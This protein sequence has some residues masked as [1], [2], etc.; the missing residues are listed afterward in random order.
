MKLVQVFTIRMTGRT[1]RGE[2]KAPL[3]TKGR[4]RGQATN[5]SAVTAV[6]EPPVLCL[7]PR[8]D[9]RLYTTYGNT[10]GSVICVQTRMLLVYTPCRNRRIMPPPPMRSRAI[11][12]SKQH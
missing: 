11:N 9:P 1:P 7:L 4:Q 3:L 6:W 2:H 10:L 8:G 12:N 5:S